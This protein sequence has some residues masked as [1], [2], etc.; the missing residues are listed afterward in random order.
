MNAQA[1]RAGVFGNGDERAAERMSVGM[2]EDFIHRQ[3]GERGK[4]DSNSGGVLKAA[5][6]APYERIAVEPV[7]KRRNMG[8]QV[9]RCHTLPPLSFGRPSRKKLIP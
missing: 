7:K 9:P 6:K 2:L 3:R 5:E 1:V 4:P 8:V